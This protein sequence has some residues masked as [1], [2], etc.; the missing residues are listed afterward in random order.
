MA[1]LQYNVPNDKA[2]PNSY[3]KTSA[4]WVGKEEELVDLHIQQ[5]NKLILKVAKM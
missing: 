5:F 1:I 4:F 2:D 3:H